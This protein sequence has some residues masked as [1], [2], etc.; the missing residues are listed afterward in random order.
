MYQQ[1][2]VVEHICDSKCISYE[3][4]CKGRIYKRC[5]DIAWVYDLPPVTPQQRTGHWIDENINPYTKR[6]YCKNCGKSAPFMAICDEHCGEHMHGETV[7]NKY[8]PN[9]GKRMAESEDYE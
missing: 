4:N 5:P 7:K 6:T 3:E 1:E 9:C 8:C 2:A